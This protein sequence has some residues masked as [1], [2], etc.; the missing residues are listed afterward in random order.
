MFSDEE[1][2]CYL[3]LSEKE[4]AE[5]NHLKNPEGKI[6][7]TLMLCYF[8][9]KNIL[10][11]ICF[12]R[13]HNDI[14]YI[15][16]T[17]FPE[18][19]FP[20][21]Y[22]STW[23]ITKIK[24]LVLNILEIP[25]KSVQA[26]MIDE[27]A[28]DLIRYHTAPSNIFKELL[29]YMEDNNIPIP[30]YSSL[31][32]MIGKTITQEQERLA[33]LV[34]KHIT[35]YAEKIIKSFITKENGL[36]PLSA[37]KLDPRSF[38][39]N[40]IQ[41]E[42]EKHRKCKK[43]FEFS[44]RLI[45][46]LNISNNNISYYASLAVYYDIYHLTRL[47]KRKYQ[48]YIIC[49]VHKQFYKI[50]NNLIDSFIHY[51]R[52]YDKRAN[53]YANAEISKLSIE[54]NNYKPKLGKV[55][56]LF[57]NKQMNRASFQ[58]IKK[59]AFN[60]IPEDEMKKL[61]KTMKRGKLDKR[62][63]VWEYHDRNRHATVINIR[64][65]FMEIDLDCAGSSSQLG[66][67]VRF[68]YNRFLQG[69]SL[70]EIQFKHLPTT[71]ISDGM[72]KYFIESKKDDKVNEYIVP[73]KYEYLIYHQLEKGLHSG[74]VYSN[75]SVEY[76]SLEADLY[77]SKMQKKQS[78]IIKKANIP[79]IS[80]DIKKTLGS[81]KDI[82]ESKLDS[83][84]QRI[85]NGENKEI[86]VVN[87]KGNIKW[88]LP[89]NK[90]D[91][92]FNNPFYD[93]IDQVNIIN[94]LAFVDTKCQFT[95]Y[96][97]HIKPYQSNSEY[98]YEYVLA[99]LLGNATGLGESKI[100]QSSNLNYDVLRH[101]SKSRIRL[102]NLHI[103]NE[104]ICNKMME[105]PIFNSYDISENNLH[106]GND[107]QKFDVRL[108]TF[109]SRYLR[110]YFKEKGVSAYTLL[111][112]NIAVDTKIITGHE[113]HYL[114]DILSN[115][116]SNIRPNIISTD[117]EGANQLNFA[118]LD[119]IG[120]LFAPCFKTITKKAKSICSFEN[121]NN[122]KD[123]IV[124]PYHRIDE[125]LIVD[126][127]PNVQNIFTSLLSGE[128]SQS[129]IVRKLSSHKRKCR[130]KQALWEYNNILMS[131][132]LL[133][134]IDDPELRKY[135]RIALN[136]VE[137][138]HQL[139]RAIANVGGGDFRGKSEVEILIW[140]E[141]ARLVANAIIYYN[142]YMLSNILEIKRKQGDQKA[143]ELLKR[144]SPIAWQHINLLGMYD[145]SLASSIAIEQQLSVMMR[146]FD[147]ELKKNK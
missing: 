62:E 93:R 112:N 80:N 110:K 74:S 137:A 31:Q 101:I 123:L 64:P 24:K 61:S 43:L 48:L 5:S 59:I 23:S 85:K 88:T 27:K 15:L 28:A 78:K 121:P 8:K 133:W 20:K 32:T 130:T 115:N 6:Y 57:S 107:G 95:T 58:K 37:L 42:I 46:K 29:F 11:K 120:V 113:S 38:R 122:Y 105:L 72:K 19:N 21:E 7:F 3:Y 13:S 117:N 142:A 94:V 69:K 84:N 109:K 63:F 75:N 22:P 52:I 100:S 51:V 33:M 89:Y 82:L 96:F 60:H 114:F 91:D 98:H 17:I 36:Y 81:L 70:S 18:E 1:R 86:K 126:E 129:T 26:S 10:Y 119:I 39:T 12:K 138:Y 68:T 146:H 34:D 50:N 104:S 111:V 45:P 145:F 73:G 53:E 147:E 127:W 55:L 132:Y 49:F 92:E 97:D 41:S 134:Y 14:S 71:H 2:Q 136:R 79:A 103:A 135:V 47:P 140:N 131:I 141:C 83:V 56:D 108:E 143:E 139:R 54:A 66:E 44:K 9:A 99:G 76:K 128:E 125:S 35:K 90:G 77:T 4:L 106:G 87:N 65:L 67:A 25:E 16:S 144:I 102:E 30:T 118:L 40:D 124:K 116:T